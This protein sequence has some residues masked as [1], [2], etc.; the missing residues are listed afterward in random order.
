MAGKKGKT[1]KIGRDAETGQFIS[2][3]KAKKN[4]KTSTVETIKKSA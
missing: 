2:V 3:D 4:P 1:T